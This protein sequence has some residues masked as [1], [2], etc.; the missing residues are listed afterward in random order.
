[1]G[2]NKKEACRAGNMGRAQWVRVGWPEILEGWAQKMK[3]RKKSGLFN[4][5]QIGSR[6]I[7]FRPG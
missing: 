4:P 7:G 2:K 6:P 1:M 5:V 3:A